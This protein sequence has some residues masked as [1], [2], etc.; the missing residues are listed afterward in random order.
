LRKSV[1]YSFKFAGG[2]LTIEMDLDFRC[3]R[4]ELQT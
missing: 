1:N 3:V 2:E 4:H